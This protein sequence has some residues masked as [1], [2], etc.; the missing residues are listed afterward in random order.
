[1]LNDISQLLTSFIFDTLFHKSMLKF[2]LK[3]AK[4]NRN[5]KHS[6]H[7]VCNAIIPVMP[8]HVATLVGLLFMMLLY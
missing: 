3:Y 4:L 2:K 6:F 5:S 1:M 7:L 8:S